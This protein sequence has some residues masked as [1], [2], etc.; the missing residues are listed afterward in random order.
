MTITIPQKHAIIK[1]TSE[2]FWTPTNVAFGPGVPISPAGPTEPARQMDYMVGRNYLVVPRAAEYHAVTFAQMRSISKLH[3]VLRTVIEKCK[4]E[5]RGI[6]WDIQTRSGFES[7]DEE[8]K[9]E[10]EFWEHPDG[11]HT[12]DQWLGALEEDRLVLDA[13]VIFK[14][15]TKG[16]ELARLEYVDGSTILVLVNDKGRVPD[17]PEPAYEQII[18]GY[19]RTQWTKRAMS[20]RPYN[21]TTE[22]VYGFSHVESII[23]TVNIALRRDT[24]F[25]E[26]FRSGNMPYGI[27]PGPE[28]WT[29]DQMIRWQRQF[30]D[31]LS[32]DL[33]QRSKLIMFPGTGKPDYV[34]PLTFDAAFDE[35]LARIICARFGKSPQPYVHQMNRATAQTAQETATDVSLVPTLQYYKSWFDEI[36]NERGK[37]YLQFMWTSG[38]LH[39]QMQDAQINDLMLKSGCATAD[40]VREQKGLEPYED[41]IGAEPMVWTNSG[42]V[43]LKDIVAGNVVANQLVTGQ[44]PGQTPGEDAQQSLRDE[45][46]KSQLDAWEKFAIH[47]LGKKSTRA[48]LTT[49]I[50]PDMVKEIGT[51]LKD[52]TTAEAVK[53]V[54]SDVKKKMIIG[55][56]ALV[57]S[58]H[59]VIARHSEP[60]QRR[61]RVVVGK[62]LD[63]LKAE[64]IEKAKSVTS[65]DDKLIDVHQAKVLL[66]GAMQPVMH[67]AVAAAVGKNRRQSRAVKVLLDYVLSKPA[68]DWLASHIGWA[69]EQ[70]SEDTADSLAGILS[71]AFAGGQ[72]ISQIRDTIAGMIDEDGSQIFSAVRAQRIAETEVMS[73]YRVGDLD[74]FR[75]GGYVTNVQLDPGPDA[76]EHC[77]AF[78][79]DI[80]T[81]DEADGL[82]GP[83]GGT[84]VNCRCHPE[85]TLVYAED[86]ERA[87]RRWYEG[88]LI[89]ITTALGYKL[90]STPNHPILTDA[91]WVVMGLLGEGDNVISCLGS[92]GM[93]FGDPNINNMPS[94]IGEIFKSLTFFNTIEWMFGS[95]MDFHGD[96][97][98]NQVDIVSIKNNLSQRGNSACMKHLKNFRLAFA[99]R[100]MRVACHNAALSGIGKS[101]FVGLTPIAGCDLSLKQTRTDG[102]SAN[103]ER[104]S[105]CK[106]RFPSDIPFDNFRGIK[107]KF[108]TQSC[109]DF[110]IGKGVLSCNVTEKQP[111]CEN[112]SQPLLT[113]VI[114]P[115]HN[116]NTFAC[117]IV[118]DRIVNIKRRSF[119][120]HVYNL[121]TQSGF[122]LANNIISHNCLWKAAD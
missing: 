39:F 41:G 59:A 97:G 116:L 4:D 31:M 119:I 88:D 15:W 16:G 21:V 25:L 120:G 58:R 109:S 77:V 100:E 33:S 103:T 89:D 8:A 99:H 115:C 14:D 30:D 82:D 28:T 72:S 87:Y 29:P 18:K 5:I 98:N 13:P 22:G 105:K 110:R 38:Q 67:K 6:D 7:Y 113:S 35:W 62:V 70:I 81:L 46:I 2:D 1:A 64:A 80:Y 23:M 74:S 49:V 10:K 78:A 47:R 11:Y 3:G 26:Y 37:P 61:M 42:P 69:A 40:W 104:F 63:K 108:A 52:A 75:Q 79:D 32:G 117:D 27:V 55:S 65:K 112:S 94:K 111:F 54:F 12:F 66:A 118:S 17:W 85:D 96:G 107:T 92:K 102:D 9:K 43:L 36:L 24:L 122:Y 95:P 76:C 34:Q 50:P 48:F 114:S 57:E 51:G 44:T 19:P 101:D 121:Q 86:I 73:A 45:T 20:Y 93:G 68:L 90:S 106:F 91:G 60:H 56:K 83:H 71:D 53:A 84:W